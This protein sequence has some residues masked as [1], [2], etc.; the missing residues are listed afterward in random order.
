ME[1]FGDLSPE[2]WYYEPIRYALDNNLMAGMSEA[3]FAP[4][5]EISRAMFV[6]VL[7]RMAGEPPLPD[8]ALSA[9]YGD[10]DG[11]GWYASA[12][13][14][15]KLNGIAQGL[16]AEEFAPDRGISREQMAIMIYRYARFRQYMGVSGTAQ[17]FADQA[18]ISDYATAAVAWCRL[19]GVL[20]GH[21]DNTFAPGAHTTRAQAA[22]LL[23]RIHQNWP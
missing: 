14:W 10:V 23:G 4:E 22:A 1:Q 13:Y 7:Y 18:D 20:Q 2:A 8:G 11:E 17:P 15:A 9:P 21:E 16:S 6:T 5:S 3:D 19:N 12:V